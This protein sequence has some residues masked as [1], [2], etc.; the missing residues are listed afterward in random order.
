MEVSDQLHAAAALA[1]EK[2]STRYPLNRSLG[3][4][5]SRFGRRGEEEIIDIIGTRTPTPRSSSP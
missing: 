5:Q 3:G 4:P 2:L 1:P